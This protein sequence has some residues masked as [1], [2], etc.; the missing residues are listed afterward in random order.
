MPPKVKDGIA[1]IYTK[2]E[3]GKSRE[4]GLYICKNNKQYFVPTKDLPKLGNKIK[5]V[6][7]GQGEAE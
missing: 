1:I 7:K 6:S 3:S 4:L 2:D 5:A